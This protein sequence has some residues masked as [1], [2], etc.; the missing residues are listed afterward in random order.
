MNWCSQ[1]TQLILSF[2]REDRPQLQ[3]LDFLHSCKVSRRW[4]VLRIDCNSSETAREAIGAS[5]L[6]K[7]PVAQMRLAQEMKIMVKGELVKTLPI[8]SPTTLLN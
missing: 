6:L 3:R 5:A 1:L 2:Y 7:A 4:G 8:D